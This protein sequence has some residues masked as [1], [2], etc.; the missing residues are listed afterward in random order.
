MKSIF[1]KEYKSFIIIG[2]AVI[3]CSALNSLHPYVLKEIIN[4]DFMQNDITKQILKLVIIYGTIHIL[5]A[6]FKNIR[7]IIVNKTVA[8]LL[9]QMRSKLFDKVLNLKLPT[10]QKYTSADIYTRLTVD[11]DNMA[12]LFSDTLPV[13]V[14]ESLYLI[15]TIIMM[16]QANFQLALIGFASL[17]V[18]AITVTLY[19]IKLKKIDDIIL[20]KRDTQ[21]K[22]YSEMYD[23]NKLTYLFNLR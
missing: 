14:N 7:N 10:F 12:T 5:Y 8:S 23:T 13:I 21:N 22:E 15:F 6:V 16:F 17:V 18:I 2:L 4:L 3:M 19:V 1:K 9:Q 20:E 11:V